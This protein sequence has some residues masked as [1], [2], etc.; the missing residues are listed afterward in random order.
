MTTG[1]GESPSADSGQLPTI[2]RK[3]VK[4]SGQVDWLRFLNRIGLGVWLLSLF[5]R[6]DLWKPGLNTFFMVTGI[7]TLSIAFVNI[8][9]VNQRLRGTSLKP[10]TVWAMLALMF[11]TMAIFFDASASTG[12]P[13]QGFLTHL[14]FLAT[15][16]SLVSV[17]GARRPGENAWALLCGLFLMIGLLP[18]MEGV[19]L[20]KR[21]DILD[22]LRFDSP[23]TYFIALVIFAGVSNYL[24]T[25]FFPSSV[26][27]GYGLIQHLQLLWKPDGRSEWRGHYWWI[28]TWCLGGSVIVGYFSATKTPKRPP[29]P[30]MNTFHDLWFPFR[31]AWGAAWALRVLER[32]NQ[33]ATANHWSIKLNWFGIY[34]VHDAAVDT[35]SE[36]N[37]KTTSTEMSTTATKT[38][39]VFIRRFGEINQIRNL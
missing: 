31:D 16:S 1:S 32:F 9:T 18:L 37:T 17:L 4:N 3:S 7:I 28:F 15:L 13:A 26:I 33:A 8:Y 2:S 23:W 19:S 24:P 21:F 35:P 38:L 10:A 5:I 11:S 12:R 34:D 39:E 27:L 14:A 29:T 36:T 30:E 22:Y 25:R 6:L 20:T